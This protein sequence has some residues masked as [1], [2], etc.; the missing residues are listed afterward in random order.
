MLSLACYEDSSVKSLMIKS[1]TKHYE[2]YYNNF[3]NGLQSMIYQYHVGTGI[4]E[5]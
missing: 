4:Y 1:L 3:E 5:K 2:I